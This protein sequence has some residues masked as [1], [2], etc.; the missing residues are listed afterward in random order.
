MNDVDALKK[1]SGPTL[2]SLASLGLA[3][4]LQT[5]VAALITIFVGPRGWDDGAITLAYSKT[6]AET[7][8]IALTAVS[9]QVEG[10]SSVSWFILN[11]L[12]ALFHPGFAGAILAAQI[13]A[14][15]FLGVTTVFIWLMAEAIGLEPRT[16]LVVLVVFAIFGPALSEIANGMEMTLLAA[17]GIAFIYSLYVRENRVLLLLSAVVFLST[18]FEAMIYYAVFLVPLLFYGRFRSFFAL[19]GFGLAVTGMQEAIR[20]VWFGDLLPNTIY[21][22]M[23]PTYSARGL[24]ALR[25]RFAAATD[26][27]KVFLPF[28]AA[29][30]AL[31]F[32]SRE[33]L[34][35]RLRGLKT[36]P[37]Q[38]VIL[39]T[40][41]VAA[42]VFAMIGGSNWGYAGRMT[43]FAQPFALLLIGLF[44][45]HLA[46][47]R[48]AAF[49]AAT[50]AV[51]TLATIVYSWNRSAP[52]VFKEVARGI[53]SRSVAPD[54]FGVTPL[55]YCKTGVQVDHLRQMLDLGTITFMTP[56]VGGLGLCGDR[57][58]VVD[59]GLLTNKQLAKNGYAA[60]PKLFAEEN[61]DIIEA[62]AGWASG[63]GLYDLASFKDNY[64]PALLEQTRFFLRI[65][66]VDAL[67][68]QNKADWCQLTEPQ[69]LRT[70]L[71]THRY[72]GHTE[73]FDDVY[74][75]KPG[76]VLILR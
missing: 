40:P 29:L 72:A 26:I 17:S 76:R 69:C 49:P 60:F 70:V 35:T 39:A 43:F 22:K 59:L 44:C 61:P 27:I 8:H 6:F 2:S 19:A 66:H 1:P 15:V 73:R 4:G 53:K 52:E 64:Q 63:P 65:D 51:I 7:A 31:V 67:L 45:D 13:M 48:K 10:F 12:I 14:A 68:A 21:A 57:I 9:E 34:Y 11:A 25:S 41:V 3:L 37:R 18:R 36:I 38:W 20:Y 42:E 74:F 50:L 71:E 30:L 46:V 5:V 23:N 55:A 32:L 54:Y 62:H 24:E 58:R 28:V 33:E 75:M 16:R 56:D 47:F